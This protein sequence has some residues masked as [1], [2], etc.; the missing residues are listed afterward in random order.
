MTLLE[1]I[2]KLESTGFPV[3]YGSFTAHEMK[4]MSPP[5]IVYIIPSESQR[6]ADEI[7]LIS[8][9]LINI[10]LYTLKKDF[11]LEKIVDSLFNCIEF[12]KS[13]AFI[14]DIGLYRELYQINIINII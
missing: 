10:E 1:V 5:Y 7:N 13:G 8:E 9:Q 2:Q 3:A 6:G 11:Q 12:E 4:T 14:N